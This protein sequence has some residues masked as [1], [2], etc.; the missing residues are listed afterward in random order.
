MGPTT[1]R[2]CAGVLLA[3]VAATSVTLPARVTHA[4]PAADAAALKK[5][6]EGRKAYDAGKFEEAL[7]AFKGS[8]ELLASPNTRLYIARCY[9]ALGK[10]ASAYT[11][12]RMASKE[13]QDRLAATGEKRYTA[14]RDSAISEAGEL[15]A[16]VPRITLA[17]P[18]DAPD[19]TEVKL[20]G[21]VVPRG[22]WGV[23]TEI[24]PGPH[25]VTA[26]G[27]RRKPFASKIELAEGQQKR[28]DVEL[29]KLATAF[30]SIKLTSRP[31]G[32]S[33]DL[34][35]K[36]LDTGALGSEQAV[37]AGAFELLVRAP[38]HKDFVWKKVLADGERATV[39]VKLVAQKVAG[40][41]A[42]GTPKWMFYA[43]AGASVVALGAGSY[44]AVQAK[45]LSDDEQA[46]N[47][48]LRDPAERDRVDSL[49]GTA[50]LLFI[51]GGALA[52]GAG[53]LAFTT[54]WGGAKEREKAKAT[55][56]APWLGVGTA[57]VAARGSF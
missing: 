27:P 40:G 19:G 22:G 29:A 26:T 34:G 17:L 47:K 7:L 4:A 41:A 16:K 6:E 38:G 48:F 53:V 36:P 3:V 39:E 25:E 55:A 51:A 33:I 11:M 50:N 13:A 37:D 43:V 52:V 28:V 49:S 32:L 44:F 35:G 46:K 54:Q 2:V 56:V 14:T 9:R 30:V 31:A 1:T 12:Y 18:S 42:K 20:D 24:D 57:G 45:S 8:L 10:P 23:A 21:E 5:F 15:E